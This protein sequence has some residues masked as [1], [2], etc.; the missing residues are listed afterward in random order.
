M[1]KSR[2]AISTAW[3]AVI[4]SRSDSWSTCESLSRDAQLIRALKMAAALA[5]HFNDLEH[6]GATIP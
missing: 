6:P 4:G 1:E 2:A 3:D 5:L